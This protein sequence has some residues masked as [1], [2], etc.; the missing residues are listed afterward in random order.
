MLVL[1]C[2]VTEAIGH[3]L[4]GLD[5]GAEALG[6]GVRDAVGERGHDV[7]QVA[8]DQAYGFDFLSFSYSLANIA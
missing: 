1:K 3:F 4:D 6:N 7:G 5:L 2:S 8:L